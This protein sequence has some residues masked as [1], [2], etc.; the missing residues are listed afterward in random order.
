M[1]EVCG[2]NVRAEAGT[3]AGTV[4]VWEDLSVLLGSIN[5]HIL[6]PPRIV[7]EEKKMA[8]LTL[9][10]QDLP[11]VSGFFEFC[12]RQRLN[13][14]ANHLNVE[15]YLQS[16]YDS[17]ALT[18]AKL[19]KL[20]TA[21]NNCFPW[22]LLCYKND[23][24][25]VIAATGGDSSVCHQE[26]PVLQDFLR[27]GLCSPTETL[28]QKVKILTPLLAVKSKNGPKPKLAAQHRN[29]TEQDVPIVY[30]YIYENGRT[31]GDLRTAA[32]W[33]MAFTSAR[34]SEVSKFVLSD[35]LG[36][37][38]PNDCTDL[39]H[40]T[41]L[42]YLR[43]AL[44]DGKTL[45]DL[46]CAQMLFLAPHVNVLQCP[47][48]HLSR[49]VVRL[50]MTYDANLDFSSLEAWG[51]IPLFP[52]EI[53]VEKPI[54]TSTHQKRFRV[55]FDECGFQDAFHTF[56]APRYLQTQRLEA[57][58][59]KTEYIEALQSREAKK[60]RS[61]NSYNTAVLFAEVVLSQT[62]IGKGKPLNIGRL[63]VAPSE[64][65]VV[66]YVPGFIRNYDES[67]V[68]DQFGNRAAVKRFIELYHQMVIFMLQ[69]EALLLP[70][71]GNI[72]NDPIFETSL[73]RDFANQV[74]QNCTPVVK[75]F[76]RTVDPKDFSSMLWPFVRREA[77]PPPLQA[78]P[79]TTVPSLPSVPAS[80]LTS[81]APIDVNLRELN[82]LSDCVKAQYITDSIHTA[83]VDLDFKYGKKWRSS[84]RAESKYKTYV[85]VQVAMNWLK[86]YIEVHHKDHNPSIATMLQVA[87]SLDHHFVPLRSKLLEPLQKKS[88]VLG[89]SL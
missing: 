32:A 10:A 88:Y 78:D 62:G 33:A 12:Y 53:N 11:Y 17:D 89:I 71:F 48:F 63:G 84:R 69:G 44:R 27:I 25:R 54:H 80:V 34:A 60:Q 49:F 83:V 18:D 67:T 30:S 4:G 74:R 16:L 64:Q 68:S 20:Q 5:L 22:Q 24:E 28:K 38:Q 41:E 65:L 26:I 59:I 7:E 14:F 23:L 31:I 46:S 1:C 61:V 86:K 29:I 3:D 51:G 81:H 6:P 13:G 2:Q 70:V 37:F 36:L 87:E 39:A 9:S 47:L 58:H 19:L 43:V 8:P 21:L 45:H 75:P 40:I 72:L 50:L 56:N 66:N 73:F 79:S 57:W 76:A 42:F 55:I 82:S 15:K 52:S 35:L 85:R 77:S